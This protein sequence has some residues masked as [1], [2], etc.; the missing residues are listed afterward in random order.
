MRKAKR[1]QKMDER[2]REIAKEKGEFTGN[3]KYFVW[4]KERDRLFSMFETKRIM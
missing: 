3:P 1:K 2:S 4:G